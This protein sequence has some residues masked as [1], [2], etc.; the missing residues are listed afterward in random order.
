MAP[1]HG[2][3]KDTVLDKIN[4]ISKSLNVIKFE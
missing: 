4:A 2:L 1:F 3:P